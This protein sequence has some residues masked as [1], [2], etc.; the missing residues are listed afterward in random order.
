M[1]KKRTKVDSRTTNTVTL[2]ITKAAQACI[3]SIFEQRTSQYDYSTQRDRLLLVDKAMQ[4]EED[5]RRKGRESNGYEADTQPPIVKPEIDTAHAFFVDLFCSGEPMF[6]VVENNTNAKG[7]KMMQA[8]VTSDTLHYGYSTQVSKYLLD[9]LKY[10]FSALE[11]TWAVDEIFQ[12]MNDITFSAAGEAEATTTLYRGNKLK[13]IDPYNLIIDRS[14]PTNEQHTRAAY[15]GYTERV[16]MLEL[17]EFLASLK[18]ADKVVMNET[19]AMWSSQPKTNRFFVPTVSDTANSEDASGWGSFFFPDASK[20]AASNKHHNVTY[21]EHYERTTMYMRIIPS[22]CGI[23]VTGK[24]RVQ[25]WKFVIVNG[26]FIVQAERQTNAHNM[27]PMLVTQPDD[28]GV[29]SESKSMAEFLIPFQN[30]STEMQDAYLGM[31]WKAVSDKGIYDSRRINKRDIESKNPTAKIAA[32]PTANNGD[33][34]GAYLPIPFDASGAGMIQ[35]GMGMLRQQVNEISGQNN[36]NR[37]Q[38]QKGNKTMTEYQDVM[39]N[40][41][42]RK[43]VQAILLEGV[44]FQPLKNIMKL[45]ILQYAQA[46]TLAA[47]GQAVEVNPAEMRKQVLEFRIADGLKNVERIAKTGA[48]QQSLAMMAPYAQLAPAY[49]FDPFLMVT[50]IMRNQGLDLDN[51]KPPQQGPDQSL[52]PQNA[53]GTGNEPPEQ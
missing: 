35:N 40:S 50:D 25:I 28:T 33:L 11:I 18:A 4:L 6:K 17:H 36:A 16:S 37:G 30:Q 19:A 27:L 22:M 7:A 12:P 5:K 52:L 47:D 13:R 24:D 3:M 23:D 1:A 39:S 53:G 10:N 41:D 44:A 31:V 34:R 29:W 20:V 21:K 14:V 48:A 9:G 8:Q 15:G 49:G 51:Y 46:T 38:F 26:Q 43:Y 2:G 42:S 45:N 32:R